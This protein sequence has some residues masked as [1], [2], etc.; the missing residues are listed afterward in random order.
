MMAFNNT[1]FLE[2]SLI[3]HSTALS[4]VD[5]TALTGQIPV[6]Q[7]T[8]VYNESNINHNTS[9]LYGT[10]NVP[11]KIYLQNLIKTQKTFQGDKDDVT[12]WLKDL[13]YVFDVAHILDTNTSG[14]ISCSLQDEALR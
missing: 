6:T 8:V 12:K 5:I 9:N 11:R 2:K 13:K 7:S 3:Y 10:A 4:D 14:L 1:Y